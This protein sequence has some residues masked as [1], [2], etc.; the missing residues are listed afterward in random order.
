[1]I[2][3]LPV[4]PS[5]SPRPASNVAHGLG[6]T[7]DVGKKDGVR[8]PRQP[9][10]DQRPENDLKA[11]RQLERRRRFPRQDPRLVKDIPGKNEKDCR[12]G[13]EHHP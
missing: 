5:R 2:L 12:L 3:A 1:L 8:I 9:L 11:D 4:V 6:L 10:L 7:L 13:C